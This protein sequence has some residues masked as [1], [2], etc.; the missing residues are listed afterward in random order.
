M[1][2][3]QVLNRADKDRDLALYLPDGVDRE[4]PYVSPGRADRAAL[5]GLPPA[6][7][8][9]AGH[10][11][12]RDEGEAYAA[13]LDE[14]GVPVR[15]LSYPGMVHGFFQMGAVLDDARAAMEEIAAALRAD[16]R[17]A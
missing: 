1:Y 4:H 14:A 16:P 12:Q 5:A 2:K 10:D 15:L 7:V 8:V 11:P 6:L 3:R 9:T 13:R 17:G